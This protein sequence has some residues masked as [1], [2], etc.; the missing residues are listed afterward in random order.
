MEILKDYGFL[1]EDAGKLIIQ[2]HPSEN[3]IIELLEYYG[4]I[5]TKPTLTK[6]FIFRE[7]A[8]R[9]FDS[10]LDHMKRKLLL[11]EERGGISLLKLSEVKELRE[12][13]VESF[14]K[15]KML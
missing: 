6:H 11:S 9:I 4:G 5:T 10:L 13:I 2:Q 15:R 12:S 1:K 14:E 7:V 3:R 8:S